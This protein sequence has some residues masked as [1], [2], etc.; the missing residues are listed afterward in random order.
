M[1]L[2]GWKGRRYCDGSGDFFFLRVSGRKM[3]GV[4]DQM[5]QIKVLDAGLELSYL[6]SRT[7]SGFNNKSGLKILWLNAWLIK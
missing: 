1:C 2:G 7:D 5:F 3:Y 6:P 4:G